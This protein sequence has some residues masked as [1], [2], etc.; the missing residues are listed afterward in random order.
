[1]CY[2]ATPTGSYK[3]IFRLLYY[4]AGTAVLQKSAHKSLKLCHYKLVYL[5]IVIKSNVPL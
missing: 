3:Y 1:M 2:F 5:Y 4:S